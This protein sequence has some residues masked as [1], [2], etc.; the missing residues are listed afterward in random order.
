VTFV[1]ADVFGEVGG[2]ADLITANPPY[3]PERHARGLQP[4]VGG[5]EPHVALFGGGYDGLTLLERV[6]RESAPLLRPGGHLICEFGFG[7][8][9][10]VEEIL[11]SSPEFTLVEL[12]RD[13]QGLA[14]TAVAIRG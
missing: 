3:V 11:E 1:Q 14:R 7:Q 6:V 9:I 13:L 4:E 2:P 12:K 8:E 10:E 5:H